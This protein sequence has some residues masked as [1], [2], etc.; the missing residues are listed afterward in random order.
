MD[1]EI[2]RKLDK[3]TGSL[4]DSGLGAPV[5]CLEQISYLIYLKLLDEQESEKKLRGAKQELLFPQQAERYSWSKWKDKTGKDLLDFVR[6]EVFYYMAN[7]FLKDEPKVA[8]YFREAVLEITDPDVFQTII[9]QLDSLGSTWD[10]KIWGDIYEYLLDYYYYSPQPSRRRA[11]GGTPQQIR[12]FMV[13]MVDP[14]FGETICDLTVG[15]GSFLIDS[16]NYILAKYSD[17]PIEVPIYGEDWLD[18]R[19]QT[20]QE[21]KQE[22]PNLQTYR[23]GDGNKLPNWEQLEASIYGFDASPEMTRIARMNLLL[24]GIRNPKVKL[25]NVLSELNGLRE[26]D[27]RRRYQVI[28][29]QPP[30]GRVSRKRSVRGHINSNSIESL[31]SDAMMRSLDEGG[32]GAIVLPKGVSFINS[33]ADVE[34][35]QILLRDFDLLAVVSLPSGV[36]F[37]TSIETAVLVFRKPVDKDSQRVRQVWFYEVKND[38]FGGRR[39]RETKELND[40]PEL[41]QKWNE[42][43]ASGFERPPG[44]EAGTLLEAGNQ[45]PN[46]WWASLETIAEND[47][48]LT[49]ELYRPEVLEKLPD[50]TP[51]ELIREVLAIESEIVADL[52]KLL[53]EVEG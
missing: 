42:Y 44:I 43:K 15:V 41:L 3:I 5:T 22:I 50:E 7:S 34:L 18:K 51:A 36:L 35:R 26:N 9:E 19:G 6:D 48:N 2:R 8:E 40:I 27:L 30:F 32:R 28:L 47:W 24:H 16:L 14:D 20:I 52:E 31:F 33:K 12:A 49:P 1:A 38:G 25:A 13:E 46:C 37:D 10:R 53:Q 11:F 45:E 23:K 21:A 4:Q 17:R 29:T 39:K